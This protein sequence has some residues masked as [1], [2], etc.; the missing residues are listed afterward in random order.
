MGEVVGAGQGGSLTCW[1][2]VAGLAGR[3]RAPA[4]EVLLAALAVWPS[5]VGT[6]AQAAPTVARAAEELPVKGAL[7]R[8][9]AAVASCGQ[10]AGGGC[11]C[12]AEACGRRGAGA[13]QPPW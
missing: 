5:C 10:E 6:A 13:N 7:L 2:A 4:I 11:E 1:V 9:A 12:K 8:V 3:P